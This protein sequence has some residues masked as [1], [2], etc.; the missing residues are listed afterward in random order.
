MSDTHILVVDDEP[1]ICTLVQEI[2]QDEGY[3]VATAKD[4]EMARAS[5]REQ[6]PDLILLDIWMPDVDG[7]SLLKEW[8]DSASLISR[9]IIDCFAT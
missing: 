1:D 4:A 6:R 2:L 5:K 3:Q 9:W 7:I 8:S